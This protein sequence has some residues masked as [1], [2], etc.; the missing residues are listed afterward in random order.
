MKKIFAFILTY[1]LGWIGVTSFYLYVQL[2]GH[3]WYHL[4]LILGCGFIFIP[5]GLWYMDYFKKT[6]GW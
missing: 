5:A 1:I 2:E 6:F 4:F 3:E